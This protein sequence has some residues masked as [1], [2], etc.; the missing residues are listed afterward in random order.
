MQKQ[1][2]KITRIIVKRKK[3]WKM[4]LTQ[5]ENTNINKT[6]MEENKSN[7]RRVGRVLGKVRFEKETY[8]KY[9]TIGQTQQAFVFVG[10]K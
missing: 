4:H 2:N 7:S 8:L 3:R 6:E 9:I 10:D 5:K 1:V